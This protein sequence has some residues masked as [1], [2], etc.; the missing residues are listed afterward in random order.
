MDTDQKQVCIEVR[1]TGI[2]IQPQD[3]S[4][5]FERFYRGEDTSGIP[6]TGL[7]LSIV[8]AV[9]DLHGGTLEIDTPPDA[10]TRVTVRLPLLRPEDG[11]PHP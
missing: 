2:G 4:H 1:D 7:G 8:K 9:V 3:M 6:G 11:N 10:S 5:L